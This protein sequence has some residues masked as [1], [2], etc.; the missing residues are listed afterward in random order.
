MH[1]DDGDDYIEGNGGSDGAGVLGG[2]PVAAIG[3]YGDTGQD[4]MIGG[5]NQ[6]DGGV[7]DGDDDA[8]GGQGH[9]VI[10]GDNADDHA[11][12]GLRLPGTASPGL[13]L[14]HVPAPNA[15]ERVIRRI[16]IW[17]VARPA[18][19][20]RPP[21][22]R[23]TTR[24]AARTATTGST[25]RAAATPSRAARTTTSRSATTAPT[26]SSAAT[27]RTTWSAAPAATD[28]A[29]PASATDGRIDANDVIQGE[30]DFD[31]IAGDNVRIVRQ[32]QDGDAG[33]PRTTPVSGRRTRSTTRSIA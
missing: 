4:D 16:Q 1:G 24:S 27:A 19:E 5:T 20:P 21:G 28:S 23:A 15:A 14:Q 3:L 17:D 26:R 13:R 8:W 31:A 22:P 6:G 7:A 12:R 30:A 9:D 11:R 32:T 33:T 10:A 25:A 18:S 2:P 29:T